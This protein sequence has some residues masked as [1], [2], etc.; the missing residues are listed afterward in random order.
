MNILADA[1]IGFLVTLLAML[2]LRPI[3]RLI[4]LVDRPGGRKMHDGEVPLVGGLAMFLGIAA[5]LGLLKPSIPSGGL[6]VAVFAVLVVVGL[7]DD[8][9]AVSHWMRL[10]VHFAAATALVIGT[11]TV[12]ARLGNP[13]GGGESS[14]QGPGAIAFTAVLIAGAINAF[15]I[16]DGMDGL[17]G[18][19]ALTS[20]AGLAWLMVLMGDHGEE[21]AIS[22]VACAATAGFLLFI[23]PVSVAGRMR[24]FM[25][26]AGSTLLGALV[27]WLC[28]RTSQYPVA[29]RSSRGW[30]TKWRL[31]AAVECWN[32]GLCLVRAT[33]WVVQGRGNLAKPL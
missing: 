4:E 6:L 29:G 19:T 25:G 21:I 24:C 7:L 22:A 2:A 26:D 8:R 9:F 5:G 15:N 14:L 28:V 18:T 17:A 12:A 10:I 30:A 11:G 32:C 23:A 16:L 31:E 27:A 1:S 13:F 3:A 33:V 20:I